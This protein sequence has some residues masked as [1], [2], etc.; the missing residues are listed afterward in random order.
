[1]FEAQFKRSFPE[2][3]GQICKS[4][5]NFFPFLVKS[6]PNLSQFRCL[7]FRR[8]TVPID[9]KVPNLL[10]P[11]LH[12]QIKQRLF[13]QVTPDEFAQIKVVLIAHVNAA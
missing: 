11:R 4:D 2:K 5:Y 10:R 7:K 9:F 1:M 12:E 6:R 8:P 13:E 3:S